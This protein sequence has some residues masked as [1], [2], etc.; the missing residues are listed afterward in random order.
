MPE[1]NQPEKKERKYPPLSHACVGVIVFQ[2]TDEGKK[3]LIQKRNKPGTP[4]HDKWE[5]PVGILEDSSQG[6]RASVPIQALREVEEEAG[7]NPT[8]VKIIVDN[9]S[10]YTTPTGDVVEGFSPYYQTHQT[11]GGNPWIMTTFLA[12]ASSNAGISKESNE[13]RDVQWI[14]EKDLRQILSEHPEDFFPLQVPAWRYHFR[15]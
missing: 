15:E 9:K 5:F 2:H 1:D 4:Y 10:S 14:P 3:Y 8:D 7:L 12:E 13:T 6:E 11:L